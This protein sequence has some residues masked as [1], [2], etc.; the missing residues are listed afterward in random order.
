MMMLFIQRSPNAI[1]L[2]VYQNLYSPPEEGSVRVIT[3][4]HFRE[5]ENRG[6][7]FP[8]HCKLG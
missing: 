6:C 5:G 1:L 8:K 7:S 3:V 2:R 4:V